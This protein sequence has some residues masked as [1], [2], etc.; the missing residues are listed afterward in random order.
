MNQIKVLAFDLMG[1]IIREEDCEIPMFQ[2]FD[3]HFSLDDKQ[4]YPWAQKK[5]QLSQNDTEQKILEYMNNYYRIRDPSVFE[6]SKEY[7]FVEA[8]NHLSIINKYLETQGLLKNF[9]YI[10][11]SSEINLQKPNPLFFKYL[12]KQVNVKTETILFV[13]D[14]EENTIS[15]KGLGLNVFNF[16]KNHDQYNLREQVEKELLKY[17]L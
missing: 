8:S 4:F 11:N 10:I 13:D 6:L 12:L 16:N 17:Q 15:A 7:L 9:K 2:D 1:V 5:Y 3:Q 14:T